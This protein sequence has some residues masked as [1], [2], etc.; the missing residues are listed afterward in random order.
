MPVNN[1]NG[2]RFSLLEKL[3]FH[4]VQLPCGWQGRTNVKDDPRPGRPIF[5]T[6]EKNI[7]YVKAIVYD[8]ARYTMEEISDISGLS[9]SYVFSILKV[10]KSV[11]PLDHVFATQK[12]GAS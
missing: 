1:K 6:S 8:D 4:F 3:P 5:A 11:R 9:E 12:K 2:S 7:S 10:K